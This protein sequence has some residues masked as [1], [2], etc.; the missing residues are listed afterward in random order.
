[1]K[2]SD[3]KANSIG[4]DQIA[5]SELWACITC[6]YSSVSIFERKH[7]CLLEHQWQL[8]WA[9]SLW[10]LKYYSHPCFLIAFLKTVKTPHCWPFVSVQC[11][12]TFI[13]LIHHGLEARTLLWK[14]KTHW[15]G[16]CLEFHQPSLFQWTVQP[17]I[18]SDG[19]AGSL[20]L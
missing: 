20:L 16:E 17:N 10:Y 7:T 4:V 2:H 14:S 13:V 1:M 6:S 3:C 11:L 18:H 19:E 8:F 9:A 15:T 12:Q 5:F